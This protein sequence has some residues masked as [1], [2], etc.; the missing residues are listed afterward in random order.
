MSPWILMTFLFQAFDTD[1][2]RNKGASLF[3]RFNHRNVEL[4]ARCTE[5]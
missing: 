2:E 5:R 1:R 3:D 4:R